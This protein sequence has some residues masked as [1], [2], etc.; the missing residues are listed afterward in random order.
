MFGASVI[1]IFSRSNKTFKQQQKPFFAIIQTADNHRPFMIPEE[2]NDFEK[3][4]LPIDTLKKYG[5]ESVNEFNSFRYSDYC[6]KKFIE[7]A[8]AE[9]YFHNTIFVFVGDHGISGNA[10]AMYP[11]VWTDQRLVMNM[12]L[13]Y[14]MRLIY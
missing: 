6:F 12:C 7:S 11:S 8:K 9:S 4:I 13:Y 2:D 10:T 14:F 1:K 5:F 3:I